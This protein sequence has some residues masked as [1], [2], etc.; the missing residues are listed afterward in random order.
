MFD[1]HFEKLDCLV[2]M[3]TLSL[4]P[5]DISLII[6]LKRGGLSNPSWQR[7]VPKRFCELVNHL[8]IV[9]NI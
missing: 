2:T 3:R 6:L 1:V 8:S 9:Q 4:S 7:K 5:Y